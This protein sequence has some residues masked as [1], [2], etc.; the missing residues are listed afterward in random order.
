MKNFE[1]LEVE[2]TYLNSRNKKITIISGCQQ[3]GEPIHYMDE[4]HEWYDEFGN[5][6]EKWTDNLVT[7]IED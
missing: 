3:K 5:G 7:L 6:C 4:D 2:N 1:T